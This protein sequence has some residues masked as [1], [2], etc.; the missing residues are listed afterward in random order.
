MEYFTVM[1]VNDQD[2]IFLNCKSTAI[3]SSTY[4]DFVT[5]L[6]VDGLD[7]L[8]HPKDIK[9]IKDA[10]EYYEKK[11]AHKLIKE[12]STAPHGYSN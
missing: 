6:R 12:Y 3:N 10:V 8:L 1:N 11:R 2:R 5:T 4:E 7:K 9:F